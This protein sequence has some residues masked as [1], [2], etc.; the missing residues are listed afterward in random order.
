MHLL[1]EGTLGQ[2][3]LGS[4]VEGDATTGGVGHTTAV[5]TEILEMCKV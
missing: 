5:V 3:I 4:S 2:T 1:G